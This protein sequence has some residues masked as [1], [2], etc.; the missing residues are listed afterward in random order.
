[1]PACLFA[2]GVGKAM[3]W[4]IRGLSGG[5]ASTLSLELR[6]SSAELAQ[7]ASDHGA[8]MGDCMEA[9]IEVIPLPPL[10]S[11]ECGVP[12]YE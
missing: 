9:V 1:M 3:S 10:F 5:D 12:I 8:I 11:M 7:H 2:G 4:K 6:G